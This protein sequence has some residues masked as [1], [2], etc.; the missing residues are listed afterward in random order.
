MIGFL[1]FS[2]NRFP[3]ARGLDFLKNSQEDIILRYLNI[4]THKTQYT[5]QFNFKD[6]SL[7]LS[8]FSLQ[9]MIFFFLTE[10]SFIYLFIYLF[11]YFVVKL[12]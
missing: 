2:Y 9:K 11:I 4:Q 3:T 1:S 10:I 8:T 7:S 6:A 12:S 5:R